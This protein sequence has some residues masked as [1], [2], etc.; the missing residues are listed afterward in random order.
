MTGFGGPSG[1]ASA[2]FLALATSGTQGAATN[3]NGPFTYLATDNMASGGISTYVY[4]HYV[5]QY[6]AGYLQDDWKLTQKFTLNLGLRYEYFTP[7][8]E[9]GDQWG[10]FVQET[11]AMTSNGGTGTAKLVF[12]RSQP[13]QKLDPNLT[14]LLTADNVSDRLRFQPAPVGLP[15]G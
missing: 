14:A 11:E 3:P 1:Y 5:H 10:N 15:E 13:S 6:L 8:I 7:Q 12:P 9:Q 4:Q 2:D